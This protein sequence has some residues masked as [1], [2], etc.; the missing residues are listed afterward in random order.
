MSCRSV[1]LFVQ[2]SNGCSPPI[3]TRLSSVV[4]SVPFIV[5]G[6]CLPLIETSYDDGLLCLT[7][8]YTSWC[9]HIAS[10]IDATF[11][12][13]VNFARLGFVPPSSIRW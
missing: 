9:F 5:S 7:V 1:A 12:A 4:R 13:S 10:T 11:R 2:V 6:R 3:P 8:S